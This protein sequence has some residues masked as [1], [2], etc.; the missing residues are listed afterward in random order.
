[1]STALDRIADVLPGLAPELWASL[2]DPPNDADIDA[3]RL[4]LAPIPLPAEL[5]LLLQRHDGQAHNGPWWPVLDCGPLIPAASI[6]DLIDTILEVAEPWQWIPS[7]IP[8]IRAGWGQA[9]LDAT[10]EASG[11]VL[12][13]SWPDLP[14]IVSP[15]LAAMVSAA[16]DLAEADL[17]P[18]DF[19]SQERSADREAFLA[20]LW[21]DSWASA[22]F[23]PEADIEPATWPERWGGPQAYS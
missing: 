12:D 22:P 14:R 5:L 16:A 23:E 18:V 21:K 13:V 15:N 19:E 4:T 10:S 11:V 8:F 9:A 3:L 7:W 17:I 2:S 20:D 6:T 1:M